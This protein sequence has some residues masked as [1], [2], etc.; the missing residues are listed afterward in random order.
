V[1][2][3]TGC[4]RWAAAGC[5]QSDDNIA[6]M[7]R[8]QQRPPMA[9]NLFSAKSPIAMWVC[10]GVFRVTGV[11]LYSQVICGADGCFALVSMYCTVLVRDGKEKNPH[12]LGSVRSGSVLPKIRVRFGF[13]SGFMLVLQITCQHLITRI[14]NK[15]IICRTSSCI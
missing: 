1:T 5:G 7:L 3:G 4:S 15:F 10:M 2:T 11:C 14:S 6:A 12:C 8:R 9:G 13:L